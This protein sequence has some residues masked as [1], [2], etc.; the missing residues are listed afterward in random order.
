MGNT[1]LT[2]DTIYNFFLMGNNLRRFTKFNLWDILFL[3]L[4]GKRSL[5]DLKKL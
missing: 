5:G 4:A 3:A 1:T 2:Y